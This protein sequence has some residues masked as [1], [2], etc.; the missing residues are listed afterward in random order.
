MKKLV[1][2]FL[3]ALMLFT[4]AACG[5]GSNSTD[6]TSGEDGSN[7]AVSMPETQSAAATYNPIPNSA[8]GTADD[9]TSDD[10]EEA[11]ET[12]EPEETV[13]PDEPQYGGTI[14]IIT[15]Q[16][17]SEPFGLPWIP[18]IAV[19][20]AAPW[21]E[22]LVNLRQDGTYEPHLAT[23]WEVDTDAHEITFHLREGIKFTDGSDWNA[24]VALWNIGVWEEDSRSNE[25]LIYDESYVVDDYTVVYK[26]DN[27]QNVLFETFASH[28]Y[29]MISM[30]NY[31]QN[32]RDYAQHN[33]VGTGPFILSEWNPGESVKFVRNEDYWMEGKPYLDAVEYYQITDVMTQS[34]ALQSNGADAV[35]EF[36]CSNAEQAWTNIQ[37]GVDF[38]YSYQR[39]GGTLCLCPN[40]EDETFNGQPNPLYDVNV[41]KA[42]AMAIDRDAICE[43]LGFGILKPANQMTGEGY[44]G[45]LPDT[46][47]NL[48][49][50]DPEAAKELLAEAGYPDGFSTVIHS[51]AQ[52][53][54]AMVAIAAQLDEIGVHCELDFPES[55]ALSDL[56][57]NGWD[58]LLAVNFGQIFNT[59]ISYY[60]W[61]HPDR[62]SY[63][64][65][66]RPPEYEEMYLEARRSFDIEDELFGNLGNMVL[67]YMTFIPIYHTFT[68]YFVRNGIHDG[69][70][71]EYSADTIWTPWNCWREQ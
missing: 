66:Y 71:T 69:G 31:L 32:G 63:V 26:Y 36:N 25:D 61:Y 57:Y 38:D 1:C 35:D 53:Q 12:E 34:A 67:E 6:T 24:E 68:V 13:N 11:E 10:A 52:F 22:D 46:N 28:T 42:L 18:I 33:P 49:T 3:A 37:A 2:L 55:G 4:L 15:T 50:Y 19:S 23:S 62:T 51:D 8:G 59:G 16:D 47:E 20:H 9:V 40:S 48:I 64:S 29:C 43:A 14:R 70:F 56:N 39:T 7:P 17:T 5:G 54:N 45:H 44:A 21:C 58:G 27:W 60:I 41:R 65:A 30:E